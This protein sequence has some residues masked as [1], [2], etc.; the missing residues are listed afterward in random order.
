MIAEAEQVRIVMRADR[1]ELTERR[2]REPGDNNT[3]TQRQA[4]SMLT[5]KL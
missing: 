3:T 2:G 5:I 4:T 1:T